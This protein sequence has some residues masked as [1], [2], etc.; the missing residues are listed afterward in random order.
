MKENHKTSNYSIFKKH[1]QNRD[2]VEKMVSRIKASIQAANMLEFRPILV[3]SEMKVI[4]GQ[5]RLQAAKE[6][7][8][9]IY[10]EIKHDASTEDMLLLNQAQTRWSIPDFIEHYANSGKEEYI[11]FREFSK[12]HQVSYSDVLK[13]KQLGGGGTYK[14]IKNGTFKFMSDSSQVSYLLGR[15][16]CN[17]VKNY[18]SKYLVCNPQFMQSSR[19]NIAL[20]D[21]LQRDD[22]DVEVFRKKIYQKAEIIRPCGD[23][24]AYRLLFKAIYNWK[25]HEPIE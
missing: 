2:V 13:N 25:N 22:V 15:D 9:E 7:G 20:T 18:M 4:D 12:K 19:F 16:L 6:L 14:H 21:F 24:H 10:Y 23:S 3:D 17:E 8:V 1:P 11:K 5:H